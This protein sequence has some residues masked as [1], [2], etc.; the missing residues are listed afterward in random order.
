MYLEQNVKH[1][2]AIIPSAIEPSG[3]ALFLANDF[4]IRKNLF[5]ETLILNGHFDKTY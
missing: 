2:R 1:S 3:C 5:N 4:S